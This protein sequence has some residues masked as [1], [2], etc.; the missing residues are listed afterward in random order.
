M[1]H[2][3][4]NPPPGLGRLLAWAALAAMLVLTVAPLLVMLKTAVEH[5]QALYA[6]A[7]DWWPSEPTGVNFVRVAGGLDA[8]QSLALGGSGAEVNF[9]RALLNSL[10]FTALV[11]ILQTTN[12]AMAAYAFARLEFPG[13]RLIFGAFIG[14]MML[15]G[16][17]LFIPNFI[18]I[19][20]LGWLGTMAGM[21]APFA[22][23]SGF[24][25]FFLR[26]FFLS[27][28]RDLEEAALLD[29]ASHFYIFRRIVLP[30]STTPLATIAMLTGIGAWN[31]FFWPFV[32]SPGEDMQVLPVALQAFKS[33]TPQGQIDW[34]G[35]MAA[36]TITVLPTLLLLMVFG[37]R[38]VES[39]QFSG[40]R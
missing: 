22:L 34:S 40:G 8:E 10:L 5:P 28:P 9:V 17:V 18:L 3:S 12:S 6:H 29:G 33:Q 25:I 14:S 27:V 24:S 1:D 37:R 36:S 35:L 19:R 16:V 31:E 21:V 39:V 32:V 2:A 11:V 26:Q 15:P 4:P 20:D 38:V 7:A 13:R 23:M 30:L